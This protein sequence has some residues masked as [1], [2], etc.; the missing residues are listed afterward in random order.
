MDGRGWLT[1]RP[2]RFSP[3]KDP[4]SIVY[5]AGWA[6]GP[7]WTV[8]KNLAPTQIRF[9]TV[10]PIVCLYTDLAIGNRRFRVITPKNT[11]H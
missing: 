7:V 6:P 4:V 10:Q 5:E 9:R 3:R 1:K 11:V 8:A 2:S